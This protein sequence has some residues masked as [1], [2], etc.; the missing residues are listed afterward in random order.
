M[1]AILVFAVL[2]G[3]ASSSPAFAEPPRPGLGRDP[4]QIMADAQI[5]AKL[6]KDIASV[7][8]KHPTLKSGLQE[9]EDRVKP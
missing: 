6:L 9:I 1:R 5:S 4:L 8:A 7:A 2:L 3:L